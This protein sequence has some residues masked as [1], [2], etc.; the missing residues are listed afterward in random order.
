MTRHLTSSEC[1]YL[2]SVVDRPSANGVVRLDEAR[3]QQASQMAFPSLVYNTLER[4]LIRLSEDDAW[5][6]ITSQTVGNRIKAGYGPFF[7]ELFLDTACWPCYVVVRLA[8]LRKLE[9]DHAVADYTWKFYRLPQIIT[10]VV[11]SGL[12]VLV[13]LGVHHVVMCFM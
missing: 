6:A 2:K 4:Q 11:V 13:L 8:L 1:A 12:G 5:D 7:D 9:L 10:C 3:F